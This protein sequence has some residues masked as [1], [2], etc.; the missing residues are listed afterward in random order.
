MKQ[1]NELV[2]LSHAAASDSQSESN[3]SSW[4]QPGLKGNQLSIPSSLVAPKRQR[5]STDHSKVIVKNYKNTSSDNG[6]ILTHFKSLAYK[7]QKRLRKKKKADPKLVDF[8]WRQI[9][10]AD[11]HAVSVFG[12]C[13]QS[14]GWCCATNK[15]HAGHHHFACVNHKTTKAKKAQDY[16]NPSSSTSTSSDEDGKKMQRTS[17]SI[18]ELLL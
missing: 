17:I 7:P 6:A 2:Q 8:L 11:I 10:S 13:Q 14:S 5:R 16:M 3:S 15:Y 4:I 9:D 1:I 18:R 12:D